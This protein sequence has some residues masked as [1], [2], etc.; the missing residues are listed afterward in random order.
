[1]KSVI[2]IF[3]ALGVLLFSPIAVAEHHEANEAEVFDA[4][5][6]V[7]SAVPKLDGVALSVIGSDGKTT[8]FEAL[9]G[10]N[11]A[12]VVFVRSADWCP[13]CKKQLIALESIAADLAAKGY[14]LIA[15]SYDEPN[16]LAKFKA[17]RELS[18][19]LV[20]DAESA[21]IKAF[22]LL[23]E[24]Y[25]EDSRMHGI[26]HPAIFIIGGDGVVKAKL[27]EEG[28]KARPAPDAVMS[29]INSLED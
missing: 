5:I 16:K 8:D 20:S 12:V 21:N 10:D 19:A 1:M 29:A 11:G 2:Q 9:K 23:N 7:G 22:G 14:P 3:L 26:P 25:D 6:A 27:M 17:K 18:F 13:Y 24:K 28:Y 15:I 4:G